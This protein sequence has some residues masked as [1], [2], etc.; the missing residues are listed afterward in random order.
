[1]K[2]LGNAVADMTSV[3]TSMAE[4]KHPVTP[5]LVACLSPYIREQI[6][7]L[8]QYVLDMNGPARTAKTAAAPLRAGL[9]T[10]F[11]TYLEPTPI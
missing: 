1:M 11:Y 10:T 9:V 6:R 7:R 8:G 2:R 5:G 3:L 4:D